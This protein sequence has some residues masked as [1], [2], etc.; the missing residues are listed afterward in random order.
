MSRWGNESRLIGQGAHHPQ[1]ITK[2]SSAL[3]IIY[4][5]KW[6]TDVWGI[7]GKFTKNFA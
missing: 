7:I 6:N 5:K 2:H 4:F 1:H 3:G